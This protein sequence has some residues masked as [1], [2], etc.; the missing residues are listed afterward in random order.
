MLEAVAMTTPPEHPKIY[1]ITHVDNLQAIVADGGLRSDADMIA[2]GGPAQAIGMSSIKRRRVQ[3]LEVDLHPG[4]KVGDYVPFYF[5]ARSVMLYVIHCA[6]HPQLAYRDGQEPIVHLE[7]DLQ[8]VV[9]WA[10]ASGR[11]WAFS[12]SNA[13]A[14]YTEFRSRMDELDQ[15]DWQAIAATDFRPAEVKEHK[16]AEFLIYGSFPFS[17]VE[18][19]GVR[20]S[21]IQTRAAAAIA[22]AAHRP[23]I[24]V[25]QGWYF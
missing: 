8:A 15:L 2:R 5:C 12:L 23:A 17:L 22:G 24:G 21:A 10:E 6:N 4:T 16:Q 14:Y 25:R 7:A 13:G 3:G 20:S 18:R 19:I 11:R 9:R 1:H